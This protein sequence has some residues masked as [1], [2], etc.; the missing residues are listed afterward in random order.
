M[1]VVKSPGLDKVMIDWFKLCRSENV[2]LNGPMT[3][4]QA[5]KYHAELGLTT[6][7]NYRLADWIN[8]KNTMIFG[9]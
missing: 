4:T 7:C 9:K 2:L 1:H 3:I 8:F 6:K 5:E